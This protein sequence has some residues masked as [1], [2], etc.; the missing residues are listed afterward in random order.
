MA[1]HRIDMKGYK[2]ERLL[3]SKMN[4]L[5]VDCFYIELI[6]E[7]PCDNKE[8]LRAREGHFIRQLGTLNA[9]IAGRSKKEWTVENSEHVKQ[10]QH[11][12]YEA[13]KQTILEQCRK[14]D[15]AHPDKV[16]EMKA[17]WYQKHK[18]EQLEKC[19]QRY[20]ENK[21]QILSNNKKYRDNNKDKL[22]E[23]YDKWNISIE[24]PCGGRYKRCKR[25]EHFKTNIHQEYENLG[26]FQKRIII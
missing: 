6:E 19:K 14:W 10:H 18:E 17:K 5:G 25:N 8:Q 26:V 9:L 22:K 13:N 3:Y 1:K 2:K 11:E 16:K 7:C 23:A 12:Y 24:C 20:E 21:E 4:E 15:E